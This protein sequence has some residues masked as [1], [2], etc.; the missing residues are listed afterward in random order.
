MKAERGGRLTHSDWPD[1]PSTRDSESERAPPEEEDGM[2]WMVVTTESLA[3]CIRF[4]L[5][6]ASLPLQP[7]QSYF[8]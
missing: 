7:R 6:D 8:T 3:Q 4:L 1:W 5:A 2:A